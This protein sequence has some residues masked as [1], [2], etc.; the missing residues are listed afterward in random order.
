[1]CDLEQHQLMVQGKSVIVCRLTHIDVMNSVLIHSLIDS[2]VSVASNGNAD[3]LSFLS[4][5]N[6]G[7]FYVSD[8]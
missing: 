7:V 8:G 5:V 1:M 2:R 4:H 3:A 6:S